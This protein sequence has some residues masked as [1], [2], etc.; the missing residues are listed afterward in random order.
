MCIRDRFFG[1]PPCKGVHPDEVVA[2]GAAVQGSALLDV[3]SGK[4]P[5]MLLLDVTS[6]NLGIMVAGGYLQTLIESNT[7][8][9]CSAAHLFTTVRDR[10]TQVK[11]VV[12]QGN[13][14]RAEDNEVLGEFLLTGLREAP[15]GAVEVEVTFEIN[16]DG[17]VSVSARDVETGASQSITVTANSMLPPEELQKIIDENKSD[18]VRTKVREDVEKARVGVERLV[19]DVEKLLPQAEQVL[20]VASAD[21]ARAAVAEARAN[22]ATG[23]A[24]A[25]QGSTAA[26]ERTVGMLRAAIPKS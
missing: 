20:G 14:R 13:S 22:I 19:R 2:L 5:D 25:L 17:I 3:D 8:V 9:P 15:R 16:S 23:T 12:L 21:S 24:E 11:I 6:H 7:T 10:Q 1:R 26:L 4:K 18:A